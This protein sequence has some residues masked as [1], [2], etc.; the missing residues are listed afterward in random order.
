[1]HHEIITIISLM[2]TTISYRYKIKEK[3][4]FSHVTYS[5]FYNIIHVV[6]CIPILYLMEVCT[7]DHL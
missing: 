7:L 4:N 5:S 3:E 2:N 6:H 1:M